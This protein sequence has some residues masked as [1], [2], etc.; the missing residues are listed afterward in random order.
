MCEAVRFLNE[1]AEFCLQ[2]AEH[3]HATE[4]EISTDW[5]AASKQ[6]LDRAYKLQDL[7]EQD[8]I[9]PEA[10]PSFSAGREKRVNRRSAEKLAR[11]RF[12]VPGFRMA[13]AG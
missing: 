6:A 12:P 13:S 8:W 4:P 5:Q 10:S 7:V 3:T 2:M 1:R 9:T 11:W